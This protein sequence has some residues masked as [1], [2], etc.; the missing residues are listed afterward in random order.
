MTSPTA[1]R[2]PASLPDLPDRERVW[3]RNAGTKAGGRSNK[4]PQ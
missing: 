2:S 4:R 1:S 3:G